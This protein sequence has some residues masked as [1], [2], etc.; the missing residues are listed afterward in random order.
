MK[1]FVVEI[2]YT[3]PLA[4]ID[5]LLAS[6]R[7]FLARGYLE[8][9]LLMSGPQTPRTGGIVL[10]RAAS[11]ED[12]E[13]FFANDPYKK[14]GAANYRFIEFTPVKHQSFMNMWCGGN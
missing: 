14:D 2:T 3:A 1:H 11:K 8:E 4:R 7:E 13:A 6:H 9:M 5:E 12:L 10:A